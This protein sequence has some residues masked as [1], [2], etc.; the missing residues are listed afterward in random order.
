M[1]NVEFNDFYQVPNIKFDIFKLRTDLEKILKNKK[2]W[3]NTFK[4]DTR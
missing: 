1:R 4:S 3:C 2:F